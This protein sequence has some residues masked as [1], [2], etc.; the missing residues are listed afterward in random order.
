MSGTDR[1][2]SSLWT[3]LPTLVPECLHPLMPRWVVENVERAVFDGLTRHEWFE[4]RV[5]ELQEQHRKAAGPPI[6]N[7]TPER[8]G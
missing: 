3:L 5:A 1:K 7:P 4:A 8:N 2:V 6:T